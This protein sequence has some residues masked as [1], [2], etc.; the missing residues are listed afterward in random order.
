[1]V[2][3]SFQT[4]KRFFTGNR[5]NFEKKQEKLRKSKV[6][7]DADKKVVF[8]KCVSEAEAREI[9]R[10]AMMLRHFF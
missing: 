4:S 9:M 5:G 10:I 3:N 2:A 7:K 6:K 1:M 8:S